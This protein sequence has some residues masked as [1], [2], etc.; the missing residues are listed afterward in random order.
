MI[1]LLI[2]HGD[3]EYEMYWN[4]GDPPV[5]NAERVAG[6]QA[7]N[8]ELKLISKITFVDNF[9]ETKSWFGLQAK[10]ISI[11]IGAAR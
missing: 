11:L 9:Q 7:N 1:C 2:K 4:T 6:I 3:K 10:K 5:T 8:N